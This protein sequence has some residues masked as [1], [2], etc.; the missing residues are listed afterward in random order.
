MK[1]KVGGTALVVNNE[2]FYK[3]RSSEDTSF[4][5][6]AQFQKTKC[7]C[8][9]KV[10][11]TE[12]FVSNEHSHDNEDTTQKEIR[13]MKLR[14][15]LKRLAVER[16]DEKPLHLITNCV[17]RNDAQ[18]DNTQCGNL[19]QV[20]GRRRRKVLKRVPKTKEEAIGILKQL[21]NADD[22]IVRSVED[23]VAIICRIEDLALL[24]QDG[25][26]LFADGTFKFAP[27]FFKQMYSFFVYR[28][29]YYIPVLHMLL[30]DKKQKTYKKA[31]GLLIDLC[32]DNGIDVK[33][34]LSTP[35]S[36]IMLDFEMAMIK[37]TKS[38]FKKSTIKCCKFHLGQS[39]WRKVKELGLSPT[40]RDMKSVHGRWIRGLFGLSVLPASEVHCIF[41]LYSSNRHLKK[42]NA[43]MIK[44][45]KY[46]K[47]TY[48][49]K[50]ATFPPSMWAG[51]DSFGKSTNNGA[52]AF[53]RHFGD[54]FGYLR[55]KPS[56]PHFLRNVSAYNT[57]K[58]IKLRSSRPGYVTQIDV[59]QELSLYKAN[60]ISVKTLLF[61]LSKKSQPKIK[62]YYKRK[63]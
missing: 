20:L 47:S 24:N 19:R 5:R 4:W 56:L 15:D 54:L 55:C 60:R 26:Q 46:I 51:L 44:L 2:L 25:L 61:T 35:G 18:I 39:C 22:D 29:G 43:Q 49:S 52:E 38:L 34:K 31:L 53:H 40:Y 23:D 63:V 6:C 21:S 13:L 28:N 30:Q 12:V 58:D 3:I 11:G 17:E 57:F 50:C 37:A 27:R 7:K 62:T 36:S 41:S 16:P 33:E 10:I 48:T 1:T 32:R 42:P 45:I 8:K 14:A 59:E 9:A